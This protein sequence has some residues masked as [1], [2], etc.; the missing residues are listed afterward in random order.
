MLLC[1]SPLTPRLPDNTGVMM[2]YLT[3]RKKKGK[4][5]EKQDIVFGRIQRIFSHRLTTTSPVRVILQVAWFTQNG[6]LF[7]GEMPLVRADPGSKWNKENAFEFIDEA[8]AQNVVFWPLDM[9][10]PDHPDKCAL[11]SRSAHRAL[12]AL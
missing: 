6:S 7:D 2:E 12:D 4:V 1:Y 10:H 3:S 9:D 8:H 5:V 11:W